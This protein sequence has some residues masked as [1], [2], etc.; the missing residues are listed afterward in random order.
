MHGKK[1]VLFHQEFLKLKIPLTTPSSLW[2][3]FNW[4]EVHFGSDQ[5]IFIL[6]ISI[7]FQIFQNVLLLRPALTFSRCLEAVVDINP[8][9]VICQCGVWQQRPVSVDVID[10]KFKG[11]LLRA[12]E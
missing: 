1:K 8:L 12:D 11:K 10:G 6:G 5:T 3:F 4:S 2:S 7:N 9:N